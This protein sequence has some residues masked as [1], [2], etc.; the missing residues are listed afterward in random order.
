MRPTRPRLRPRFR[1]LCAAFGRID[2][3]VCNAGVIAVTP[4]VQM[5]LAECAG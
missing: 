3:M 5:D 4:V 2:V 1:P